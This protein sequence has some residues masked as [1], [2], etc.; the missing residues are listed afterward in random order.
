MKTYR[1][2]LCRQRAYRTED[3]ARAYDIG[4]RLRQDG[5]TCPQWASPAQDGWWDRDFEIDDTRWR[6][7]NIRGTFA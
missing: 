1:A 5:R 4:V 3:D 6:I 2:L 7:A